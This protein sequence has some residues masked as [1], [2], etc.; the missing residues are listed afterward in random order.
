MSATGYFTHKDC[1]AHEMGEGH[2][3]CPERLDAIDDWLLATGVGDALDKREAPQASI[4]DLELAH[5]RMMVAGLRGLSQQLADDINAG[6]PAYV[7][8]DPDTSLNLHTWNAALRAAGA[9]LAATDSVIAGEHDNAFCAVRPPGHHA[10][11]DKAMGFCF[12]NNIAIAAKYAL[13]RHGLKRVAIVDFDVHHGNGTEDIIRGDKRIL[14]VSFF[15][16]P[17]YPY[18]GADTQEDNML[19]LPVP[20]YTKGMDIREIV[21]TMWIPRLADFRPDMIF[22]SAGFD[23]HRDD[24]LGQMGLVEQDYAWITQRIKDVANSHSKGRI[25]SAL[26]G[27][28][29]LRA[30]ARSV[31][32]HIRV[33]ADL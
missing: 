26:E 21:E 1:H 12:F 30:L 8:V 16:H 15:Q 29:N 23:A 32:A 28:Y 10:C 24:D 27:G 7:Q 13:E 6:G 14:M 33:L 4:A 25:V 17:L 11:S 20:A 9:V 19:N 31:E 22:I 18:S 2:P 3:E 5:D